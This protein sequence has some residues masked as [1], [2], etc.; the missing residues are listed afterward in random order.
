MSEADRDRRPAQDR[1]ALNQLF[2]DDSVEGQD[3]Q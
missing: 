3:R 1:P 2:E